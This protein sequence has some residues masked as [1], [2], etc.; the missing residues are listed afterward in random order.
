MSK[1]TLVIA[2]RGSEL[3]LAQAEAVLTQCRAQFPDRS[4][5][6]AIIKTTGD[7]IQTASLASSNLPK[8]LFTKE[9]ETALLEGQAH[10]AVHSLK[11]LPTEL[12]TGL[13]LGATPP[14]EDVRDVLIYRDARSTHGPG[15]VFDRLNSINDLPP[16]AYL[17][18][19]STRRAA[20]A[21]YLRPDLNT[22]PIRGN[23]PT[24][25]KKLL[26]QPEIDALVLAAA[27]LNR[28]GCSISTDGSLRASSQI[29][30]AGLMATLLP[31]EE[32]LPCVGQGAIA[33]ETRLADAEA[34]A[35]CARLND[36]ATFQCV[37]AER[38]LLRGL[39]G[40][41]QLPIGAYAQL[42]GNHL[43]LRAVSFL[44][45]TPSRAEG[46]GDPAEPESLG[47]HVASLLQ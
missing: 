4:F 21:R 44:S 13:I 22:Q 10:L 12:P 34:T 7:K 11:D 17:A 32:M 19:S 29:A 37:R 3:A 24:R 47:R 46:T 9:L 42:L 25:L 33:I 18:T 31:F 1:P 38:A 43:H 40:G 2:T 15:R 6:I 45:S 28:L 39:G 20:Q 30:P 36:L 41:C 27:G 26:A 23:V 5:Q 16:G 14:R 35:V 8:G